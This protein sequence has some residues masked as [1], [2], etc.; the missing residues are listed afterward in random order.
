MSGTAQSRLARLVGSS[1]PYPPPCKKTT[2]GNPA[3]R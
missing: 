1:G 3:C 2:T